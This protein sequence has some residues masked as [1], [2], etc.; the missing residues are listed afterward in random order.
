MPFT[1]VTVEFLEWYALISICDIRKGFLNGSNVVLG[2]LFIGMK[3]A[4][5]IHS[6][7]RGHNRAANVDFFAEKPMKLS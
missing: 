7:L 1:K 2:G 4:P 3:T 6:L 5:L